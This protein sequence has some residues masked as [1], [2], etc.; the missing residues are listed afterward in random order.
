MAIFNGGKGSGD[1]VTHMARWRVV[2]MRRWMRVHRNDATIIDNTNTHRDRQHDQ[3]SGMKNHAPG[4]QN[5]L[6]IVI[7]DHESQRIDRNL[8][9]FER[10]MHG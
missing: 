1:G 9:D 3:L 5:D 10:D 7:P 2:I 6:Q 8:N 4:P